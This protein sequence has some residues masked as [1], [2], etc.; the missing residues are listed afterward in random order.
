MTR[1]LAKPDVTTIDVED[2]VDASAGSRLAGGRTPVRPGDTKL[3]AVSFL[4]EAA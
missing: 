2:T 3:P 4:N 1:S